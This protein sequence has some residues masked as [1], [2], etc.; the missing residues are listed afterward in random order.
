MLKI[1]DWVDINKIEWQAL[2][3]RITNMDL[4]KNNKINWKIT[5]SNN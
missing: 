5:K 3:L 2:C 4:L 1:R